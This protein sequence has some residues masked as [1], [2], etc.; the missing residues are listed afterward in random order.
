MGHVA[1]APEVSTLLTCEGR[2]AKPDEAGE[3]SLGRLAQCEFRRSFVEN[4]GDLRSGHLLLAI[5]DRTESREVLESVHEAWH[6]RGRLRVV[7][8]E[9]P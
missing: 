4:V 1:P 5:A 7:V 3:M 2:I 8:Q 6:G 9:P